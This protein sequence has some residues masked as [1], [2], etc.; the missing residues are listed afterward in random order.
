[1]RIATWNVNSIRARLHAVLPW[2]DECGPDILLLQETKVVDD[3][4]P[5]DDFTRR[6][7]G[8][9]IFGQKSYNGVAILARH[10]LTDVSMG[11]DGDEAS[12]ERRFLAAT[13]GG[14]RVA[15]VYVP[16]GK[17]V[18]HP[19]FAEKLRWLERLRSTLL[20]QTQR[21]GLLWVVG[22][23][24][25]VA[26]E[27]RDVWAPELWE[28]KVHFHPEERRAIGRLLDLGLVDAFRLHHDEPAKFS[29]WD[30][31]GV[32]LSRNQGLRID[33]LFVS[34]ALCSRCA[35]VDIDKKTRLGDRPSD[36]APVWLDLTPP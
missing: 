25:N 6:G 28:G 24:F 20:A 30:Y 26:R 5:T 36:H 7:Y 3:D 11:L 16:N 19:A 1:M 29:W 2:L 10:T 14:V 18:E 27:P 12:A 9:R 15:S 35:A 31:R 8:V 21:Y 13:V 22:G 4:F 17:D 34:E 33:Y 32:S 23:D